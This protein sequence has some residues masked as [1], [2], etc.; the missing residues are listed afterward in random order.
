M[1]DAYELDEKDIQIQSDSS[2]NTLMT[3]EEIY[4]KLECDALE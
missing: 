4:K 1:A 3:A 2:K